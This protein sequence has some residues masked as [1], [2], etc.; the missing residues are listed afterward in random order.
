MPVLFPGDLAFL[1][2]I[3]CDIVHSFQLSS[4]WGSSSHG[5]H[6]FRD[7]NDV[8]EYFTSPIFTSEQN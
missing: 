5:L 6:V 8:V 1:E 4:C 7:D 3:S 2:G